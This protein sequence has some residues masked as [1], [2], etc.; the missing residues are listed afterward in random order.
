LEPTNAIVINNVIIKTP[1]IVAI[2]VAMYFF[3]PNNLKVDN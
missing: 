3:M 1:N 2:L